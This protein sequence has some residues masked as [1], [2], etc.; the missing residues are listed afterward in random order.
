MTWPEAFVI[1]GGIFGFLFLVVFVA[2]AFFIK[3]VA[4]D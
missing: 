1:V 4:E 3:K 2:V